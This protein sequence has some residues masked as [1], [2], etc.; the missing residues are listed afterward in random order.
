MNERQPPHLAVFLLRRAATSRY[1]DSLEGDLLEEFCAGRSRLWYWRQVAAALRHHLLR[2]FRQQAGAFVATTAFFML[3]LWTIAPATF[4]VMNWAHPAEPL[5]SL[6][7]L[8]WLVAVP[9]LLGAIAG[10]AERRR[11][12]GTILLA[13][14]V[15]Y[16]TPVT[17]P[18]DSAVC[19]LCAG[20][21]STVMPTAAA[22]MT[23]LGF[24]LLAGAGAWTMSRLRRPASAEHSS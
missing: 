10:A 24:A 17:L 19:D 1:G 5:R 9:L 7:L 16:L 11:R 12:V 6:T 20:P 13:A 21:G 15:A 4:P 23:P 18:L 2:V 14:G 22:V 8:G 3:A